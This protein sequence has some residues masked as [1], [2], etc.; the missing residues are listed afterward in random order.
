MDV[1]IDFY[2]SGLLPGQAK[3]SGQEEVKQSSYH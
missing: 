1:R 3:H 2:E